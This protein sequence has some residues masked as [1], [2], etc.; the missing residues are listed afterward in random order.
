MLLLQLFIGKSLEIWKYA[1][2]IWVVSESADN[3]LAIV[4]RITTRL[5]SCNTSCMHQLQQSLLLLQLLLLPLLLLLL[6]LPPSIP[7]RCFAQSTK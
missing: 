2:F 7:F 4:C 3:F 5:P 6:Q 1:R